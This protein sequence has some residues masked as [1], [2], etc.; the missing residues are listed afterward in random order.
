MTEVELHRT[1]A[2]GTLHRSVTHS[3]F[4]DCDYITLSV[5]NADYIMATELW[6]QDIVVSQPP[7]PDLMQQ[8]EKKTLCCVEVLFVFWVLLV[9]KF[10]KIT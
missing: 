9:L 5:C 4:P 6:L 7:S 10:G 3:V 2:S 8:K 1:S